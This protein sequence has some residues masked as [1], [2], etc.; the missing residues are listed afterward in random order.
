[1]QQSICDEYSNFMRVTFETLAYE[2]TAQL[3]NG[4][5]SGK[6]HVFEANNVIIVGVIIKMETVTQVASADNHGSNICDPRQNNGTFDGRYE[7][8]P[9]SDNALASIM[10]DCITSTNKGSSSSIAYLFQYCS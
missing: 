3:R 5:A 10:V 4:G 6:E 2:D 1:M 7:L 8:P 9:T